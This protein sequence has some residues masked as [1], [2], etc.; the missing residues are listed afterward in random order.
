MVQAAG[1]GVMVGEIFS[2][3]TLGTLV[4][5]E[6]RFNT[7]AYLSIV[8]VHVHSFRTTV[9]DSLIHALKQFIS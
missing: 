7:T 9:Y 4:P 8:V 5:I 2:W 1:G 3:N 6:H